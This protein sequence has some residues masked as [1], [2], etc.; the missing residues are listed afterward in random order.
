MR[1]RGYIVLVG[2]LVWLALVGHA[3]ATTYYIRT[4]GNNANTGTTDNAGGAWATMGK[5]STTA[6]AGDTCIV[7]DGTYV[8]GAIN[9]ATSGTSGSPHHL[10]RIWRRDDHARSVVSAAVVFGDVCGATV[11][12]R[13]RGWGI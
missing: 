6:V 10:A 8:E 7:G 3:Q 12:G 13:C 5:C 1:R 9:F 2:W 11:W 4:D